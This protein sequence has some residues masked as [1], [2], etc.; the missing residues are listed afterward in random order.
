MKKAVC[1]EITH[2]VWISVPHAY[3]HQNVNQ[4]VDWWDSKGLIFF[5]LFLY[6][7]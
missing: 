3:T 7:S 1:T 2:C 6:F 4:N 5:L